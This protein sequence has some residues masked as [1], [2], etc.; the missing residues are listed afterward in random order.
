VGAVVERLSYDAWGKRRNANGTDDLANALVSAITDH[1]Y[2][3]RFLQADP[4][5]QFP[6]N[7]QSYNRYTYVLNNPSF[8]TDPSGYDLVFP[9][10]TLSYTDGNGTPQTTTGPSFNIP[11]ACGPIANLN[12]NYFPGNPNP[13]IQFVQPWLAN[14][15]NF[16]NNTVSQL[17]TG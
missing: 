3:G 14:A 7:L 10:P 9:G 12:F 8:A 1:G 2:T 13:N 5:L 4:T 6:D 11:C 15:S 16:L 17:S